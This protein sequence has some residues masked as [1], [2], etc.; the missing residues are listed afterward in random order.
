[1]KSSADARPRSRRHV[2]A[3][4]LAWRCDVLRHAGFDMALAS[5]LAAEGEID[6]HG[7]LN[8]VDRGCPPHLAARI[9]APLD[10]RQPEHRAAPA[11]PG[12]ARAA[13]TPT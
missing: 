3:D 11:P 4:V 9:L 8:L 5:D 6:L 1:M 2:P 13:P 12:T 7:L 10:G